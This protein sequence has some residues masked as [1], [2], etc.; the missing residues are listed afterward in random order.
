MKQIGGWTAILY[1]AVMEEK[2][3]ECHFPT[4]TCPYTT[5]ND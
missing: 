3:F 5:F 1:E 4:G 2:D